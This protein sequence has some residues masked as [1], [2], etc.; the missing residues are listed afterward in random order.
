MPPGLSGDEQDWSFYV[1]DPD[2]VSSDP[3]KD[4]CAYIRGGV[5][6]IADPEMTL[7]ADKTCGGEDL[8]GTFS[9][10]TMNQKTWADY[11]KVTAY[12]LDASGTPHD[13]TAQVA[14]TGT[15]VFDASGNI[16]LSGDA[17]GN[18]PFTLPPSAYM[19]NGAPA[20]SLMWDIRGLFLA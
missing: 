12:V 2:K 6:V 18:F 13:V 1:W 10:K 5:E 3:V 14:F 15:K 4:R 16:L 19:I 7:T 20:K 17:S 11:S 9:V 8:S